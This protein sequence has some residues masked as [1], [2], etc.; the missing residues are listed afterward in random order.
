MQLEPS[1][2]KKL[3]LENHQFPCKFLFKF[4]VPADQKDEVRALIPEA[5][6]SERPSSSGK[7]VSVSLNHLVDD[8]EH[9]LKIYEE[10]A[11]IENLISL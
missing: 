9:V 4:V 7:Y 10:A 6:I 8:V 5:E 11:K 1:K 3:L 2:F